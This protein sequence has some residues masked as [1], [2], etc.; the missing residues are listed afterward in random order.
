MVGIRERP[1]QIFVLRV[2]HSEMEQA[3]ATQDIEDSIKS[4]FEVSESRLAI[5]RGEGKGT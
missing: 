1:Q 3:E 2:T 5:P 4:K